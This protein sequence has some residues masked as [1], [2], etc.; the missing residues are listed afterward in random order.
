MRT[1]GRENGIG[2]TFE[3][4]V[5]LEILYVKFDRTKQDHKWKWKLSPPK[6]Q[7]T[8]RKCFTESKNV[9]LFCFWKEPTTIYHRGSVKA[10]AIQCLRQTLAIPLKFTSMSRIERKYCLISASYLAWLFDI[11]I[12]LVIH[13]IFSLA[14]VWSK[15]I[16]W[17]NIPQLKLGDIRD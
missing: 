6:K 2:R 12:L 8:Y 13:Q 4:H 1:F 11:F 7:K 17:P 15:H 10:V 14:R 9:P 3:S 5:P 16:T